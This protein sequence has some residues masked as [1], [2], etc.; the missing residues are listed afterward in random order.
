[1]KEL[2][3]DVQPAT[4]LARV[5]DLVGISAEIGR[6][7][8]GTLSSDQFQR[9]LVTF[10]LVGDHNVLLLDEPTAHM[11]Q[12]GQERR[13]VLSRPAAHERVDPSSPPRPPG[14]W[15]AI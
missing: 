9:L 15:R 14:V 8:I 12:P 2:T 6:Q 4:S 3:F 10:A 11:D 13:L 5:M 1:M 7:M